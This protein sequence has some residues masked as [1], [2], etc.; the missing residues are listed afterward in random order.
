[1]E[2][3]SILSIESVELDAV[4][5][6]RITLPWSKYLALNFCTKWHLKFH[7]ECLNGAYQS[8]MLLVVC[9]KNENKKKQQYCVT[10]SRCG[11][12][13]SSSKEV[14]YLFQFEHDVKQN[15][16]IQIYF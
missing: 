7:F 13:I 8:E 1:M 11:L 6:T 15:A 10:E 12:C 2:V 9:E 5:Y 3:Y 14:E 16:S 4:F